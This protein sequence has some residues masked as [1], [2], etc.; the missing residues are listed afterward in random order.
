MLQAERDY[1]YALRDFVVQRQDL[2][3]QVMREYYNL[4]QAWRVL[5]NTRL[6][7][8]QVKLVRQRSEALFKVSR[9]TSIDVLRSQQEELGALNR[10][11]TGGDPTPSR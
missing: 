9:A 7:V 5:E 11:Q 1:V 10:L 2:A 6:N 4:L 3:L 8:Q